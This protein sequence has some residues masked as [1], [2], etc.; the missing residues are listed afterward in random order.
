MAMFINGQPHDYQRQS[1][2]DLV[3]QLELQQQRLAIE[4]N[5]EVVPRSQHADTYVNDGDRIEIVRAIGGG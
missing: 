4:V 3:Q 2:R 1:L 5:G